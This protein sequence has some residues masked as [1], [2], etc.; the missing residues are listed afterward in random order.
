MPGKNF[1]MSKI[2]NLLI[3]PWHPIKVANEWV[4]PHDI[5]ENEQSMSCKVYNLLTTGGVVVANGI[6]C[7]TLGHGYT[8][9]VIFHEYF[10]NREKIIDDLRSVDEKSF[11]D[12]FI[13]LSC[14]NFQ[15]D[16]LFKVQGIALNTY[17]LV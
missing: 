10:G 4:F 15:R 5:C 13:D 1:T 2:G 8:G 11:E 14:I 3:T 7:C 9:P 12:G 17:F 6:K 16:E